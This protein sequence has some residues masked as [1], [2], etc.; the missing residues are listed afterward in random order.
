LRRCSCNAASGNP[1]IAIMFMTHFWLC[2]IL[3]AAL[4]QPA[5]DGKAKKDLER[6]QGAWTMHALE[7]DGKDLPAPNIQGTILTIKGDVYRTKVKDKEL[8]GFRIK[9]DPSKTPMMIDMIQTLPG[10][11]EKT[12]KGIYTF[13]ND[14]FKMC[15]GLNAEQD[16][17]RQFATWP[18]T[19]YFVVTWKK[20]VK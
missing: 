19:S 13:E 5:D 10:G 3:L 6:M 15:R 4:A 2:P 8:S 14:T 1:E 16:R 11:A 20:Q 12:F 18:N 7:I 17:P 9:L